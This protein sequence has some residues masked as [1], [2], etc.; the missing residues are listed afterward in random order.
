[1]LRLDW[2][3]Q[4]LESIARSLDRIADHLAPK[5]CK[6]TNPND[7]GGLVGQRF[8]WKCDKCGS[9]LSRAEW[10]TLGWRLGEDGW[11]QVKPGELVPMDKAEPTYGISSGV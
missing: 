1:M 8:T 6:H 9:S 4:S 7:S 2:Q 3:A 11:S 5:E 10:A